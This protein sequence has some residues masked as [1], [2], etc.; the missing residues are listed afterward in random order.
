MSL[1]G[2]QYHARRFARLGQ[3]AWNAGDVVTARKYVNL[4]LQFNP[5]LFEAIQLREHVNAAH[6]EPESIDL[7]LRT[8][9]QP[10]QRPTRDYSRHGVPWRPQ[11]H[12]GDN[13]PPVHIDQRGQPGSRNDLIPFPKYQPLIGN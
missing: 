7:Y 3:A 12:Q 13:V 11:V 5:Q 4:S 8:G 9:L 1:I 6:P 2:R 10:L